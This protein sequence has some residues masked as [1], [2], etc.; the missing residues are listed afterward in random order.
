[1]SLGQIGLP[2]IGDVNFIAKAGGSTREYLMSNWH[3]PPDHLHADLP[4][5]VAKAAGRY[6]GA[7]TVFMLSPDSHSLSS[8]LTWSYNM[9]HL[10]GMFA[11]SMMNQRARIGASAAISPMIDVTGYGNTFANIYNMW[12]YANSGSHFG[13]RITGNRNSFYNVHFAGPLNTTIT[14]AFDAA[15]NIYGAEE[16]YF[17]NCTFGT[18]TIERQ[19][20]LLSLKLD[21]AG[22]ADVAM[23]HIFE[24]C[25]FLSSCDGDADAHFIHATT[26]TH[27][28]A[29]FKRCTFINIS[30]SGFGT[31]TMALGLSSANASDFRFIM[32]TGC[33]FHGVTDIIADG[34]EAKVEFGVS[35]VPDAAINRGLFHNPDH[36]A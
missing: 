29:L 16:C 11:P 30:A 36:T 10:V 25:L 31:N 32:D 34:E 20:D 19:A 23:R 35:A 4:T 27:G 18:D 6:D 15:C 21:G 12:G 8:T 14:T 17:K 7:N 33:S 2:I 28:W 3:V 9:T 5:A 1:M 13:V 22:G 26:N 24:D